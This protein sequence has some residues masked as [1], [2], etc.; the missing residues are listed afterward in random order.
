MLGNRKQELR[1]E[2]VGERERERKKEG[3][4]DALSPLNFHFNRKKSTQAPRSMALHKP[5]NHIM[6]PATDYGPF[7]GTPGLN[8]GEN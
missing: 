6:D 5:I 3:E 8:R 1:H 2:S 7:Y 4:K